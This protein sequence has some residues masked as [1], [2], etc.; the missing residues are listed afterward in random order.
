MHLPH[1][2]DP[3]VAL[4]GMTFG[5]IVIPVIVLGALFMFAR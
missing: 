2:I 3:T 5:V 1:H 4:V